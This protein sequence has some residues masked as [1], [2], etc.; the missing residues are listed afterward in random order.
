MTDSRKHL[1]CRAVGSLTSRKV[2]DGGSFVF[3]RQSSLVVFA[4]FGIVSLDVS[5]MLFGQLVNGLFD[6]TVGENI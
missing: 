5:Q 3:A 4:L 6:F 2:V 1:S